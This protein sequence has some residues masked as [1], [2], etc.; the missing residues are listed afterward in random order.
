MSGERESTRGRL[1]YLAGPEVFL[2]PRSRAIAVGERKKAFCAAAGFDATFPL[3]GVPAGVTPTE[4]ALEIFDICVRMMTEADFVIANMTP[5]RGV[6]MDVGTAVEIGYMHAL[7]KPVFGYT[8]DPEP[9]RARVLAAG[10]ATPDAEDVEDFEFA[11]N[12]MCEGAVLRSSGAV[13]RGTA[14]P[15]DRI[16]AL[17]SFERC[18]QQAAAYYESM[19]PSASR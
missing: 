4:I 7:G 6:S 8:N 10:V 11:D 2:L 16:T 13:V 15:G 18:V 3:D 12:L 5:F 9:Y 19:A 17:E 1:A 14:P